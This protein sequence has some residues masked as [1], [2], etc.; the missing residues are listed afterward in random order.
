VGA[1]KHE[2]NNDRFTDRN[3]VKQ[4]NYPVTI[5][6]VAVK[7]PKIVLD[8]EKSFVQMHMPKPNWK[9]YKIVIENNVVYIVREYCSRC[10]KVYL[11]PGQ[12]KLREYYDMDIGYVYLDEGI[13]KD[14]INASLYVDKYLDGEALTEQDAKK[15]FY[16]Y[17]MEYEKAWRIVLAQAPR[18]AITD[19]EWQ[20]ACNFFGGCAVCGGPIQVQAKFFPRRFNG[21]HTAWNV[22]PMCEECYR[23]HTMGRLDVT[24]ESTRYK[25]FSTHS[26]FQKTKTIRM[27][28]MAQ[29]QNHDL[30]M[31]PLE[32]WRKRFFETKLLEGSL[33][34]RSD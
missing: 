9:R 19:Q 31:E 29:M 6:D 2:T 3:K 1:R 26:S 23:K 32:P 17:G 18:E 16:K 27:Y 8:M 21:E 10:D 28:L 34:E 30:Y 7:V 25:I 5:T 13:C 11:Y 20:H 12:R 4:A 24:K 22:V 15:L 33:L 14:C